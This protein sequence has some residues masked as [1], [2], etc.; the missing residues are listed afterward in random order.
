MLATAAIFGFLAV[1]LGAFG[2]H[3][4]KAR[5]SP[6]LLAVYRTGV[7][8]HFYHALALL[9]VG[10]L[11]LLRPSGLLSASGLCFA[12]GV[13]IFSGSLYALALSGVRV[14]GAITPI[15]GLLFLAGWL[16]L[17]LAAWREA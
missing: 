15:D 8:Y 14:L 13:L 3:A 2:S 11:A 10:V 5:L 7:E 1:A 9:A 6:E 17:A 12:V 4:L 16:L